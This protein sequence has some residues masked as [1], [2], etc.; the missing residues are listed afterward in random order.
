MSSVSNKCPGVCPVPRKITCFG[1]L[2][3]FEMDKAVGVSL[4]DVMDQRREVINDNFEFI[5][6]RLKEAI[7]KL[8]SVGFLHSD[9]KLDN[10][11]YD[12]YHSSVQLI[13]FGNSKS[14]E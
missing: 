1:P 5:V 8:H 6:S 7:D 4:L 3:F 2:A 14:F 10:V 12:F 9:I 13:D 11:F